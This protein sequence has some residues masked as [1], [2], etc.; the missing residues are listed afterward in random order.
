[1]ESL[2]LIGMGEGPRGNYIRDSRSTCCPNFNLEGLLPWLA[3]QGRDLSHLKGQWLTL[4]SF[5]GC[6]CFKGLGPKLLFSIKG[7][8]LQKR[9]VL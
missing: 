9:E 7:G 3:L 8:E 5:M 2:I 1:V 4:S 6:P